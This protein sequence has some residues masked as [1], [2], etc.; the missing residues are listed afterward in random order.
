MDRLCHCPT[1]LAGCILSKILLPLFQACVDRG[2]SCSHRHVG[3]VCHQRGTL[4]DR[5]FLSGE[6]ML[7][8]RRDWASLS[9]ISLQFRLKLWNHP[10]RFK[11]LQPP[12]LTI[13]PYLTP[14]PIC[15]V[16]QFTLSILVYNVAVQVVEMI[17]TFQDLCHHTD[18]FGTD[19]AFPSMRVVSSGKSVNTSAIS[20]PRSPQPTY[21]ASWSPILLGLE[22]S[23]NMP[24]P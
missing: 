22:E 4:H 7:Q 21:T 9:P 8:F 19:R 16:S 13:P 5:F 1:E 6:E 20:L 10:S 23:Q 12:K 15:H 24:K 3:G 14:F 11:H 18:K 2:F 17:L